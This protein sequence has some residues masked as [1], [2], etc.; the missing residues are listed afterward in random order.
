[1]PRSRAA[2]MVAAKRSAVFSSFFQVRGG[3][4][5]VRSRGDGGG[6]EGRRCW[7]LMAGNWLG[8]QR[9]VPP[10]SAWVAVTM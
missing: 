6:I 3:R 1:M 4:R 9:T 10:P 5:T 8:R 2:F 7:V